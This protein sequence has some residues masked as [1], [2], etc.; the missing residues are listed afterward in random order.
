MQKRNKLITVKAT[1]SERMKWHELAFRRGT[2]LS[3]LIR[4]LLVKEDKEN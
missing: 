1:E 3:T 4:M 2:N